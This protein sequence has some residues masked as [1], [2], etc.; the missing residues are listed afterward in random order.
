MET[1]GDVLTALARRYAFGD[2][3]ALMQRRSHADAYTLLIDEMPT[4][5]G[6]ARGIVVVPA[7]AGLGPPLNDDGFPGMI[8]G[9]R[10][11]H[12][13]GAVIRAFVDGITFEQRM[14]LD[15]VREVVEDVGEIR[16]WGGAAKS[17]AWC[18][19]EADVFHLPVVRTGEPD[20]SVA[21]AAVCSAVAVGAVAD[22]DQGIAE[23]IRPTSSFTPD[24]AS[25]R[26]YDRYYDVY[27]R[28]V[29]ALRDAGVGDALTGLAR[30]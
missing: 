26:S 13:R 5:P 8:L 23:M 9:L 27:R 3:E 19:I 16:A 17:D 28:A 24:A 1:A 4:E 20:A 12:D 21:G 14:I 7:W 18:Q 2:L 6:G 10:L 11:D 15:V 29:D 30:D 22:F 25:V